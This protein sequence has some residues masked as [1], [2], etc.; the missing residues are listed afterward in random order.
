MYLPAIEL[1]TTY[2][3]YPLDIVHINLLDCCNINTY[4]TLSMRL[5]LPAI[6]Q[7]T[8]REKSGLAR[9]LM[10]FWIKFVCE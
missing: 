7:V 1:I 9:I 6:N 10:A 4:Y 8:T 2:Y 3:S 5:H